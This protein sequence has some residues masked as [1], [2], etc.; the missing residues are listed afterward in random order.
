[1]NGLHP[2][3]APLLAV[4]VVA[5]RMALEQVSPAAGDAWQRGVEVLSA[6]LTI[7]V[8]LQFSPGDPPR[9]P[10]AL[11]MVAIVVIVAARVAAYFGL[12]LGDIKLEHL[13]FILGN[14][15][16]AAAVIGFNR[17]LGSSELLSERTESARWRVI[18]FVSLLAVAAVLALGWNTWEVFDRGA[19]TTPGG[20]VA[21]IATIVSTSCDALV[22]AG[23]VYL[24]WL[25][26]PLLGGSLARPYMLLA[27]SAGMSLVVDFLLTAAGATT[28]TELH[29][30]N[31]SATLAKWLGC[32][33][34]VLIG[35]A[36]ATQLW[37]LRS[38][39][40]RAK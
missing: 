5:G 6:A 13:C 36:A 17:V 14:T 7:G 1:M 18:A 28:Q 15:C 11:L 37:L 22:C 30:F 9:R 10:W 24:V 33:A 40:R 3:A 27:I 2:A 35:L 16:V 32:L 31:F 12:V 38:A 29:V 8:F 23:G 20:W 4:A 21:T 26:R 34:Y 25:V 19:P 39:G